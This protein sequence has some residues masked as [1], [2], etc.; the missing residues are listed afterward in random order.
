[1]NAWA[2]F[3]HVLGVEPR[4]PSTAYN[5]W[6]GFGSDLT[7]LTAAA[8]FIVAWWHKHNCQEDGCRRIGH[9]ITVEDSGHQFRRCRRHHLIRHTKPEGATQ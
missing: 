4:S 1:M 8:V 2:V 6:S 7:E 3:L 9:H 5:F